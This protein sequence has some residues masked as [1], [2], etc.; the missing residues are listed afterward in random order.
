MVGLGLPCVHPRPIHAQALC[1][2]SCSTTTHSRRP[3]K[4]YLSMPLL[5][6]SRI[7]RTTDGR[8]VRART[9][10]APKHDRPANPRRAASHAGDP[11]QCAHLPAPSILLALRGERA[12]SGSSAASTH[13]QLQLVQGSHTTAA[14]RRAICPIP[15]KSLLESLLRGYSRKSPPDKLAC[16]PWRRRPG[17]SPLL[18]SSLHRP[19]IT[20]YVISNQFSV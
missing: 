20:T 10:A 2:A 11:K 5:I 15:C 4:K 7:W 6:Y 9:T 18:M 17:A 14:T 16:A 3:C 8:W 19:R 13:R 12:A 1:T